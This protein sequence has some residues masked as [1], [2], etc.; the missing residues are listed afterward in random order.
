MDGLVRR[1]GLRFHRSAPE[2]APPG[3][4]GNPSADP[5]DGFPADPPA[6]APVP[7]VDRGSFES[8][9]LD[10]TGADPR[11]RGRPRTPRLRCLQPLHDLRRVDDDRHAAP[12]RGGAEGR[13]RQTAV[14]SAR[15]RPPHPRSVSLADAECLGRDRRS[16]GPGCHPLGIPSADDRS[17]GADHR[18]DPVADIDSGRVRLRL[19][20]PTAAA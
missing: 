6:M 3:Q 5:D 17:P 11:R 8:L 2:P 12:G 13:P 4:P 18:P 16:L 1:L 20:P 7:P 15:P 10:R 14:D 19:R 9:I